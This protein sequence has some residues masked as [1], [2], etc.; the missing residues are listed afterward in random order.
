MELIEIIGYVLL[1][2]FFVVLVLSTL[3][4][5]FRVY[6]KGMWKAEHEGED[7]KNIRWIFYVNKEDKR[8]FVSNRSVFGWYLNFGNK[9]GVA[10]V[11]ANVLL[12]ICFV[13]RIFTHS[14]LGFWFFAVGFTVV[15]IATRAALIWSLH[16]EDEEDAKYWRWS[17][18]YNKHDKRIIVPHR[19]RLGW[20]LNYGN[21][22][23]IA[24]ALIIL[25][26]LICLI[27]FGSSH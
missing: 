6:L 4:F 11:A 22:Y 2:L 21:K 19:F 3:L 24:V 13:Y 26:G 20:G 18:Y 27:F 14:I 8:I 25:L 10:I 17:V 7:P 15:Y 1:I 5:A 23:G 9:Y 12:C 16:Q